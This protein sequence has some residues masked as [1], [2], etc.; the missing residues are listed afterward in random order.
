MNNYY[1]FQTYCVDSNVADSACSGTAYLS[2]VKA[3]S[4]TVGLSAV[5]K[6]G[7]CEGQRNSSNSV[8]GLMSWA[9]RA[10]KSTGNILIIDELVVLLAIN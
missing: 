7:D 3:N 8:T 4:G 5:V 10:G 1:I 2:G 6:R 9:Q